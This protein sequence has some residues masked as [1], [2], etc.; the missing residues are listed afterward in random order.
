MAAGSF[1]QSVQGRGDLDPQLVRPGHGEHWHHTPTYRRWS[2][3]GGGGGRLSRILALGAGAVV[4]LP[5]SGSERDDGLAAK[6]HRMRW[7]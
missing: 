2:E 7:D 3:R 4:A 6:D 5:L 1:F